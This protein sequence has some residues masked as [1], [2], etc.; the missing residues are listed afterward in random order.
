MTLS[1]ERS[2][3]IIFVP[4]MKPKPPADVH[5]REL[6]RCFV[7]GLSRLD[8]SCAEHVSKHPQVFQLVSWTYDFYGRYR[9]I[10][11]DL[12]GIERSLKLTEP[13]PEDVAEIESLNGRVQRWIRIVGDRWPFLTSLLAK[14][15][16]RLT[17]TEAHR[18]LRDRRGIGRYIRQGLADVIEA[19]WDRRERVLVMGHSLGSVIA[20]DTLW[21]L[22]K[23]SPAGMVE[24]FVTLGSPLGTRFIR[25]EI[26]GFDPG[27]R[28]QYPTNIHRWENF[29]ARGEMTALHPELQPFFAD[30]IDQGLTESIIDHAGFYN[31]FRGDAGLNVHK[32]YGYLLSRPVARAIVSWM[33]YD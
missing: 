28:Q 3:R 32:S 30:M 31:Y 20:Y 33:L 14:P 22:S 15:E 1:E 10:A 18:Y 5:H 7:E 21:E 8:E 19:A 23:R 16:M 4:G 6:F 26:K 2:V 17:M 12:P 13:P 11:L 24:L 25:T 9:D 27:G 29:S